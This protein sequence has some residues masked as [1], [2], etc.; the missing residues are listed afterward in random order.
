M[1]L[2]RRHLLQA[3]LATTPASTLLRAQDKSKLIVRSVRPEDF[4]MP[5]SGFSDWLTPV[6]RFFV[7]THL[8]TPQVEAGKWEVKVSG[9]VNAPVTLD[10]ARIERLPRVEVVSVLECAG[11]GRSFYQPGMPGMQWKYGAVGNARWAGVRLSDVLKL[12]GMKAGATEVVVNGADVPIGTMPDFVRSIPLSKAM[13]PNTL[14]A[15]EMNGARLT[16]SH[17]FPLRLV[18]PGWAG[19]SWLKWVN[20]IEVLDKEYDGF[21]MKSAYRYP[22]KPIAPRKVRSLGNTQWKRY[23]APSGSVE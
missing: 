20:H 12:A 21:F 1:G 7:R 6:E 4:E 18:V 22:P 17:G 23:S 13:D 8:Y 15:Y 3:L 16:P 2:S 9:L 5:L 10:M 19:D 14:L 11:N